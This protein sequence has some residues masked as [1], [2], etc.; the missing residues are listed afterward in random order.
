[1]PKWAIASAIG[2]AVLLMGI[3]GCVACSVV[4]VSLDSTRQEVRD[5]GATGISDPATGAEIAAPVGG[6]ERVDAMGFEVISVAGRIITQEDD[7]TRFGWELR[8]RNDGDDDATFEADIA[9][10]DADGT[11][12][13]TERVFPLILGAGREEVF[14]GEATLPSEQAQRVDEIT[15]DV[16]RL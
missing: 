6:R 2:C 9:F 1:M 15:A 13:H 12:V 3:G 8:L 4:L 11:V 7:G 10:R 5:A 16:R 14:D